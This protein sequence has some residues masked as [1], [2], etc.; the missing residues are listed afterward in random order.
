MF[1]FLEDEHSLSPETAF[2]VFLKW[3]EGGPRPTDEPTASAPWARLLHTAAVGG[4][5]Q[6]RAL[7]FRYYEF[8]GYEVNEDIKSKVLEWGLESIATGALIFSS[9]V[10]EMDG[11]GFNAALKLFQESG[12]FN[13]HYS[14]MS[15]QILEEYLSLPPSLAPSSEFLRQPLNLWGD[16]LP[17]ILASFNHAK[18]IK[19]LKRIMTSDC[20][21]MRNNLGET[22]LY[23]A[24]ECGASET[25]LFLLD[26]GA[27]PSL[28]PRRKAPSC[29]HWLFAFHP[30]E[31]NTV[32]ERLIEKGAS[33]DILT[34]QGGKMFHYPFLLPAGS[35]LH[36][37]VRFNCIEAV[38]AVLSHGADPF[39][40]DGHRQFIFLSSDP[41][42]QPDSPNDIPHEEF[43]LGPS[44]GS[45][46]VEIAVQNWNADI[47]ELLIESRSDNL[48]GTLVDGIGILHHL[49]AG[50]FCW[51]SDYSPSRFYT[52]YV[53]GSP[54]TQKAMLKRTLHALLDHGL[55]IDSLAPTWRSGRTS[56]VLMLAVY[57]GKPD[58]V[59]MLLSAGANVKTVDSDGRT[60]LMY[61]GVRYGVEASGSLQSAEE[62]QTHMTSLLLRH[63]ANIHVRDN[64]GYSPVLVLSSH[65]LRAAV[66]ILLDRGVAADDKSTCPDT[67]RDDVADFPVFGHLAWALSDKLDEDVESVTRAH[68]EE[69]AGLLRRYVV[70]LITSSRDHGVSREYDRKLLL[71]ELAI[72][73]LIESATVLLQAGVAVNPVEKKVGKSPRTPLDALMNFM[74]MQARKESRGASKAEV[75][76]RDRR[77]ERTVALLREYG[78]LQAHE[79]EAPRSEE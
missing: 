32:T 28:R 20:I 8:H 51:I 49:I 17:H 44:A 11:P 4:V 5:Q 79:L 41:D 2:A 48:N 69:M 53:R 35:P 33:T 15:P 61:M 31:V 36:W 71:H 25:V 64:Q 23:R 16:C 3:V 78:A 58:L 46:A 24:C 37:A 47:L 63:G 43:I 30:D 13:Q 1:A 9:E 50:E 18:A 67:D 62:F 10:R 60:A 38:R 12:G 29:L 59:E 73:G 75:E 65:Y 26:M 52:P 27:N 42:V 7:I 19:T 45:S 72:C 6:A 54:D 22:P 40:R 57:A 14:G 68:D 76:K 74:N 34:S 39:L 55:D 77:Y 56:T 66:K 70:P 21:N